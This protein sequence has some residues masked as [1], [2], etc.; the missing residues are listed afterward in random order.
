MIV[1]RR[2]ASLA[3]I[4]LSLA[5]PALA[6]EGHDPDCREWPSA[7][8]ASGHGSGDMPTGKPGAGWSVDTPPGE[9]RDVPLDVRTGTWM[10]VDVSP[11]G[12][13]IV[14]DLLGDLYRL[15]IGGGEAT[16][17]TSGLAWD[18][19]PRWRPDGKR[20]AFTSDR[21]GGD[22]LWV[23]DADGA[24]PRAV[25]AETFRLLN[26]P[27]WTPDGQY[28]AGRKHFTS[29]RSAGAG[30]IWLYHASG[31]RD[32][33]QMTAR[34]TTQKDEGEPAFSPDGRYLYW[35]MDAT[36]GNAFEY[37]KDGNGQIYTIQRLDRESGE[38]VTIAG[39][40]GGAV[41]PTPS[42]DGRRLAF[43]RRVRFE[44]VLHVLDLDT[45]RERAVV[46]GLERDHQEIWAIH[47]VYPGL[48]WT[49]D[50]RSIVYWAKG[51]LHR[52]DVATRAV[53]AIPFHVRDTRRITEAV[54]PVVDV[55]PDSVEARMLRW[56]SVSPQ[57]D[58]VLYS[59]L[60][61]LWVKSL[62]DG[63][64]RRLTTQDDHW[65]FYPTWSRDGR[66][67]TY[68]SWNDSTLGAVR[69]VSSAGGTAGRVLTPRP[70]RY[71]EP[72]FSPDGATVVYRATAAGA[73]FDN[74][75]PLEHGIWR[76]AVA[77]GTPKR[78]TRRGMMPQFGRA[79]DRLYLIDVAGA[80][81]DERSL[82]SIA[83]DGTEERTHVKGVYFTELRLSPD[84]Q[85]LAFRERFKVW[86]APAVRAGRPISIGPSMRELPARLVSDQSGD[87]I[88]WSAD[89]RTLHWA[90][91][92]TLYSR[93]LRELFAFVPGGADSLAARAPRS[94]PIGFKLAADRPTGSIAFVGARV[95]TMRGDEVIEDGT[96]VVTGNRIAAVG[97][98][99][100]VTIPAGATVIEAKGR[101]LTPG[102]VDCHWH[103][104]MGSE[105]LIPQR[106]WVDAASLAF[107][108]TTLHDPS[109]DSYEI[110]THAEMQRAG[111]LT[112]PRIFSTG[113]ILY[114]AK[115][116]F[117]AEVDSVGDALMHLRRMQAYG[118]HSVKSYNQ[119]RR[120][121]RQQVLEAAR[122]LGMSVVPEG[123]ALF[124]H[125]MTMV[126][127][128]HTGVEHALPIARVYDDV[129]QLWSGTKVGYTP[130]FNVAYG[131]LDG[132]HYFYAKTPVW[133][134][135]RLQRFVPRRT[136]DARARRPQT[137]PDDE[138]NHITVAEEANKLH[139]AG[140]GVQ[141][142]AH[143]QREGLG[144]HWEIWSLVLGGMTPHEALRCATLGGAR[145]LGYDRDLGSLEP[146]KL[147]D[148]LVFDRDPLSDIRQTASLS[149]VMQNVR[150][151]D[152]STLDEIAPRA[153]KRG[154]F[155]WESLQREEAA[156][157]Q[158]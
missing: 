37:N 124:P 33:V 100:S 39:G 41:R 91:G 46:G 30:E 62:P 71:V 79:S 125:N 80:D 87:W 70:G 153:R 48:A 110:F 122:R 27:V 44:T 81:E 12:R 9:H 121:Q 131:G 58:R 78:I 92:A 60:G 86:V 127:D 77:G 102:F 50:G 42:P 56:V 119:P 141:I 66:W 13:W 16:A 88:G 47:G 73:L 17:L 4:V 155:W 128:G 133:A 96:V 15:P 145:Y 57:G 107:G 72:A 156:A 103:G 26:S 65:E 34:R 11:D 31:G 19:Q 116:D 114:G 5:L 105:G 2:H 144:A 148:L 126:I 106:S 134:D 152:A 99:A 85:W 158:R 138:W 129:V 20:I 22:N 74:A 139:R 21:S 89:S 59:A 149:R 111:R 64:P 7:V 68:T 137:A 76:V 157:T 23:M 3:L 28:L 117:R 94:V 6:E 82:F 35:S 38:I 14:F 101:T 52:V 63:R 135:E 1:S 120:D 90:L 146:G 55:A 147:A 113:T 93:D 53:T 109:N 75:R 154:A 43:L 95:A 49:P 69:V 84:E 40:P 151:Y 36:P 104:S 24:N 18:E 61:H 112:A 29:T 51:S 67:V 142:G 136:L 98:R 25:T 108:V 123:G 115:G 132:E 143:G 83:L 150:L 130:T 140:V 8:N 10:S 118:A 32:G 45:G 54:R 97:P